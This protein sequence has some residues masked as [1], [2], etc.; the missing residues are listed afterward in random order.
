MRSRW[1]WSTTR[2][3]ATWGLRASSR[4]P[5]VDLWGLVLLQECARTRKS[6]RAGHQGLRGCCLLRHA[7]HCWARCPVHVPCALL[8]AHLSAVLPC[9]TEEAMPPSPIHYLTP[10]PAPPTYHHPPMPPSPMHSLVRPSPTHTQKYPPTH[11]Q[12]PNRRLHGLRGGCAGTARPAGPR[13]AACAG[14]AQD[15]KGGAPGAP[16]WGV[17]ASSAL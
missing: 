12:T 11:A 9:L 16:G 4:S 10:P 7:L 3:A 2:G 1:M 5:Q 14:I 17:H 8:P 6:G 15:P 13:P